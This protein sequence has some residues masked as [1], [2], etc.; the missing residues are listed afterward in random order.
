MNPHRTSQHII[1]FSQALDIASY[2]GFRPIQE[3]ISEQRSLQKKGSKRTVTAP[4]GDATSLDTNRS[5]VLRSFLEEG[6]QDHKSLPLHVVHASLM[7][8]PGIRKS[9]QPYLCLDIIDAHKSIAEAVLIQTACSILR[10]ARIPNIYVEIN[11]VGDQD[12]Y[13]C[14]IRECASYYRKRISDLPTVGRELLK[15]DIF[16]LLSHNHEKCKEIA[17]D[18]P[19]PINFLSEPHRMHF[20]EVLEYLESMGIPYRINESMSYCRN[21]YSR[22]IFEIK[23]GNGVT[24]DSTEDTTLA[25]GGRFDELSRAF[26]LRKNIPGVGITLFADKFSTTVLPKQKRAHAPKVFLI[27][28]GFEA[29]L[30]SLKVLETLRT[31]RIPVHQMLAKDRLSAQISLAERLKIPFTMIIGQREAMDDTVILRDMDTRMQQVIPV[32]DLC[33]VIRAIIQ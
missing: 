6:L 15:K 23:S 4:R 17:E 26:G 21:C 19:K 28:L 9:K 11:S 24:T 29:K 12:A 30:L 22:T 32:R 18:A 20:M 33:S 10:N 25:R 5:A 13:A 8:A 1:P 3:F 27:Q 2:Y 16:Q 14:F 31:A 7:P